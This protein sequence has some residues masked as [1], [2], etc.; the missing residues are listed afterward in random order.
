MV[1]RSGSV[2][3]LDVETV[4]VAGRVYGRD[5]T[6]GGDRLAIQRARIRSALNLGNGGVGARGFGGSRGFGRRRGVSRLWSLGRSRG[7]GRRGCFTCG[8]GLLRRWL[9][10]REV[11]GVAVGVDL[12]VVTSDRGGVR[13]SGRS[14]TLKLLRPAPADEVDDV[15]ASVNEL[16]GG[17]LRTNCHCARK[18]G[19]Y[20]LGATVPR[21]LAY[22]EVVTGLDRSRKRRWRCVGRT[23]SGLTVQYPTV[24][25]NWL[26]RQVVEL[27]EV[28]FV[29]SATVA[30]AAVDLVDHYRF[31]RSC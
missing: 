17:T 9:A 14:L 30:A 28:L 31:G 15:A 4:L 16:N 12:R 18:V 13:G 8:S 3:H 20:V 21:C 25:R 11:V 22:E 26:A 27:D 23:A 7:F 2:S 19:I 24:E 10:C 6:L 5:H 29:R 1:G